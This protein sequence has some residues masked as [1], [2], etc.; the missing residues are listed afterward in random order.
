MTDN[1]LYPNANALLK[2]LKEDGAE[3]NAPVDIE[4][5]LK[6]LDITVIYDE[7][8][9]N[10][11]VIGEIT[12]NENGG[13]LIKVNPIQNSY[14]TRRRFTLAHEIGHYC[15]HSDTNQKVFTD[16]R[17]TMN[18]SDSYWDAYESQAN[19]FAAQLLMPKEL[20][21]KEGNQVIEK[22]KSDSDNDSMPVSKFIEKMSALFLVSAE[23]MKYRLKNLRVIS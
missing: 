11:D 20:L 1:H 23:A 14:E 2:K 8:L 13:P 16:Y 5:I 22:Y 18:R 3:I 15:L 17:K 4:Y 7:S 19:T 12:F 10:R 6:S 9:E 21:I